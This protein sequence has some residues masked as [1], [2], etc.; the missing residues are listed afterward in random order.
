M[1]K[2][3]NISNQFKH[4]FVFYK[5]GLSNKFIE[6]VK[7][8]ELVEEFIFKPLY[9]TS[10]YKNT[11]TECT[12]KPQ[13][14]FSFIEEEVIVT[15]F[16]TSFSNIY[17]IGKSYEI[18]YID[19]NKTKVLKKK[20]T[21][22]RYDSKDKSLEI[23]F[24]IIENR[25]LNQKKFILKYKL[26]LYIYK[27]S[28]TYFLFKLDITFDENFET[29]FTK[30]L[31]TMIQNNLSILLKKRELE[32]ISI[33]GSCLI[34]ASPKK[35]WN[36]IHDI[37]Q[38]EGAEYMSRLQQD[39]SSPNL[40]D[41]FS[42]FYNSVGAQYDFVITELTIPED[43]NNIWT[44]TLKMYKSTPDS[45]KFEMNC[46]LTPLKQNLVL[47]EFEHKFEECITMNLFKAL[48]KDKINYIIKTKQLAEVKQ[49]QN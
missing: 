35:I 43:Q 38:Y 25:I 9:L 37:S 21:V 29:I 40:G 26:R 10:N 22:T 3:K 12:E 11:I 28:Q 2:N 27:I 13:N 20:Y 41:K 14:L 32:V 1:E 18:Y 23:E 49:I 30:D 47:F 19:K 36:V 48:S 5:Y 16:N 6:I 45:L 31:S 46:K 42:L 7:N 8:P 4:E 15:K 24:L 33:P 39:H 44:K 34:F 17:F